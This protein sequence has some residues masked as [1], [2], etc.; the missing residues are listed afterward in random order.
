MLL[1]TKE[2]MLI[3]YCFSNA[4]DCHIFVNM[5][6]SPKRKDHVQSFWKT[7][8]FLVESQIEKYKYQENDIENVCIPNDKRQI[9]N[10][11]YFVNGDV[12]LSY[13]SWPCAMCI[14]VSKIR[15]IEA[16]KVTPQI[17]HKYKLQVNPY[18]WLR[19]F[20]SN[21]YIPL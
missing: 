16:S 11:M 15:F 7:V 18:S 3:Q 8:L 6:L 5:F 13:W 20:C 10:L 12:S 14:R 21:Y 1:E 19:L 17:Q 9:N 4:S 2:S